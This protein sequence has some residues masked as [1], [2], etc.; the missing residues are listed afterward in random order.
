[1]VGATKNNKQVVSCFLDTKNGTSGFVLLR[2][3]LRQFRNGDIWTVSSWNTVMQFLRG[4]Q[5]YIGS[6]NYILRR[7][8]SFKKV[9]LLKSMI[10]Y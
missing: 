2:H 4:G 8:A 9:H 7:M 10:V 3:V 6:F 5:A 1:M